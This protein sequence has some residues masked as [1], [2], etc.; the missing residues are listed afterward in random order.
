[1]AVVAARKLEHA[2]AACEAARQADRTHRRLGA[3]RDQA[4]PLDGRH[5]VDDLGRKLD[6]ALG[7]GAERGSLAGGCDDGVDRVGIRVPE[8][9]R[10]PTT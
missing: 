9:Q 7:R 2:I 8:E 1:V 5:R 10:A 3:R 6:L 4:D